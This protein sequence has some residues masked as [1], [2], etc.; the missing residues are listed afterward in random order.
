MRSIIRLFVFCIVALATHFAVQTNKARDA[1]VLTVCALEVD[2][3]LTQDAGALVY[4]DFE[5]APD[6]RPTSNRGGLVQLYS[7]QEKATFPSR[8]KG[9]A[10]ANPPAPEFVRLSKD[11]PNRAIAFDYELQGTNEYAGVGV[12]IYGQALQDGKPIADDVSGYKFLTLQLYVT[13]VSSITVEFI[14]RNQG[15]EIT[16]GNPRMSFKV[17]SGFNTYKVPLNS[18]AQPSWADVKVKVKDVL[19]K[20]TSINVLA[21]CNQ[22]TNIKGTVVIDNVVFQN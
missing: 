18:L 16:N 20:L 4:A 21:S 3:E 9:L 11:N 14:S 6:S 7:Y 1:G 19:K 15:I 12:E 8:Y 22:C 2:T 13:G 10:S 5:T 17:S